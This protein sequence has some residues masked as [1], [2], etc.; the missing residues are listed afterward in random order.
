MIERALAFNEGEGIKVESLIFQAGSM[1]QSTSSLA[2]PQR[3]GG[4]DAVT[5]AIVRLDDL[6]LPEKREMILRALR[7]NFGSRKKAAG[8]LGISRFQLYRLMKKL[9]ISDEIEDKQ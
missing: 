2:K 7:Q 6:S 1:P 8:S 9:G 5:P 4:S 3:V